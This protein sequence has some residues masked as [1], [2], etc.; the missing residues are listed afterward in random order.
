MTFLGEQMVELD[1]QIRRDGLIRRR[2]S[3][4]RVAA[5]FRDHGLVHFALNVEYEVRQLARL[6]GD[7]E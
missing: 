5:W 3:A 6:I 7:A 2:D 4:R 1:A